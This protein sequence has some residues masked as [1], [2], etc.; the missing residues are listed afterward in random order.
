R[1]ARTLPH[2]RCIRHTVYALWMSSSR[3]AH[4]PFGSTARVA[5]AVLAY[6]PLG[7]QLCSRHAMGR[8]M[9]RREFNIAGT[10]AVLLAGCGGGG[11]DGPAT[12]AP[13]PAAANPPSPAP[14]PNTPGPTPA[15]PPAP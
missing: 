9:R 12:P 8:Q 1:A 2:F 6:W 7:P 11:G 14:A 10:A 15:P 4:S 3:P 5:V 13:P